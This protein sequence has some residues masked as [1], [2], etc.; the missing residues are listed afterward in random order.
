[1]VVLSM[2]LY[3][4]LMMVFSK[5]KLLPEILTWEEKILITRLSNIVLLNS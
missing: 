1:V 4:K 3:C 5:L 2:S